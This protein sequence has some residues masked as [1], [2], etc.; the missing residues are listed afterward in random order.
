MSSQFLSILFDR[1]PA[2]VDIQLNTPAYIFVVQILGSMNE[3]AM[4]RH[5]VG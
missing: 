4:R 2:A 3:G 1:N 5:E